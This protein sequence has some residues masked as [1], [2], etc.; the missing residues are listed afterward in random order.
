MGNPSDYQS[1]LR[2]LRNM[3]QEAVTVIATTDI[4][5]R[6]GQRITELLSAAARL[7][8][9]LIETHPAVVLGQ[10]GGMKTAERGSEYYRQLATKRKTRAGGRPKKG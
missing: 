7:T 5:Q 9:C 4:P 6:R 10:R 2:A 1:D 8:D 3:I